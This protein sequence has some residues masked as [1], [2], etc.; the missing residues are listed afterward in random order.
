M[1]DCKYAIQLVDNK[2]LYH[3]E[4]VKN[5]FTEPLTL[6]EIVERVHD[7]DIPAST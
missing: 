4:Q 6:Q 3:G 2:N 7:G 5:P 1:S